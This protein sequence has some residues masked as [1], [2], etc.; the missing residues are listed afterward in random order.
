MVWAK[1]SV[2]QYLDPLG[3]IAAAIKTVFVSV[4]VAV[5]REFWD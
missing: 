2:F 3:K 1:Y 4:R 5:L